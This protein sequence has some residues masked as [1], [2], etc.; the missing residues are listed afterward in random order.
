MYLLF[1]IGATKMRLA[2]SQD[3]REFGEPKTLPTPRDFKGGISAFV[4][5]AKELAGGQRIDM[6]VGGIVGP[7]NKEKTGLTNTPNLPE[8]NDKPFK[9]ELEKAIGAPVYFENDADLAGLGE[10]HFGAGKGCG[11]V[12]YLTIS[13]GVGGGRIVDGKID[14]NALGFEPGHQII[15]PDGKDLE[16]HISGRAL[17]ERYNKPPKEIRDPA[18]WE[19]EAVML[20]YGLSNVAVL[21]SPNVI[22][23]GGSMILGEPA[24]PIERVRFHLKKALK[25]FSEPPPVEKSALGDS[26]GLYGASA[27]LNQIKNQN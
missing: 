15:A 3:G 12:A 18:V 25:I 8:W 11:I 5:T 20:A 22:I 6:A 4:E 14:R 26:A 2:V 24:I 13:T 9:E 21:W 16:E 10:A 1:D 27:L 19:E 23:L 17:E 7:F